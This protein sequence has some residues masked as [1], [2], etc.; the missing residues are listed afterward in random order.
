MTAITVRQNK[1]GMT[2]IEVLI[3][4]VI[5]LVLFL[6]LMQSALLSISVNVRNEIR[7]A[8]ILLTEMRMNQ[9]K[10]TA[11][12]GLAAGTVI[13]TNTDDP[14]LSKNI[15]NF[16]INYTRTTTITDMPPANPTSKQLEVA[17]AWSY[18]GENFNHII[19]TLK[20]KS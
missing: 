4:L 7:D 9:L 17:I 5:T 6:A 16:A 11:F 12:A 13:E 15:R 2:L 19:T 3:A 10:N 18:R 20:R 8:A 1:K 14:E